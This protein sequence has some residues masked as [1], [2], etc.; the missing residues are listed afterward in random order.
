M[1]ANKACLAAIGVHNWKP[2]RVEHA[3][4]IIEEYIVPMGELLI[5]QERR[6][7]EDVTSAYRG[8]TG[9]FVGG[10]IGRD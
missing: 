6:Y 10:A 1:R 2:E 8:M 4:Q 3:Y 7:M 5:G 9:A